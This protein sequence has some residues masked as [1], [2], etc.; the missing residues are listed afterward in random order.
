MFYAIAAAV[1]VLAVSCNKTDPNAIGSVEGDWQAV[2]YKAA[3]QKDGKDLS[4]D[5]VMELLLAEVPAEQKEAAKE[6]LKESMGMVFGEH[7]IPDDQ[8]VVMCLEKGGK[9]MGYSKA[10]GVESKREI[11]TWSQD[12][13]KLTITAVDTE[14]V[15][16][17]TFTIV[18]AN[19]SELVIRMSSADMDSSAIDT[20]AAESFKKYGV[21]MYSELS[22]KKI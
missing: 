4:S 6:M 22:F 5:E 19:A 1:A 16:S 12:G 3:F 8:A 15:T 7:A 10:E 13:S 17:G 14:E 21:E 11:G 2:S 9:L 20:A 18:K